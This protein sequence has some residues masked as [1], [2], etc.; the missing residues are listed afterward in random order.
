[1][2]NLCWGDRIESWQKRRQVAR[3]ERNPLTNKEGAYI[4]ATDNNLI[5]LPEPQGV[6]IYEEYEKKSKEIL[7]PGVIYDE[8]FG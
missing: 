3:I 1:L 2:I 8:S 4:E 7:S 6:K 5:F